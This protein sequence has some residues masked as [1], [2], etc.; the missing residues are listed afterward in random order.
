M[1]DLDLRHDLHRGI[2]AAPV[3]RGY[4]RRH[5]LRA[6]GGRRDTEPIG[7]NLPNLLFEQPQHS[8]KFDPVN[9]M[10][11]KQD[12]AQADTS[13]DHF[14]KHPHVFEPIEAREV[15]ERLAHVTHRQRLP[16]HG[17]DQAADHLIVDELALLLEADFGNDGRGLGVDDTGS[18]DA[19]DK[20]AD[21]A[22]P[23]QNACRTRTSSA[24][25]RS[26]L[27]ERIHEKR[28]VWSY[29]SRMIWSRVDEERLRAYVR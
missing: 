26:S 1:P 10:E 2:A 4:R 8:A 29:S 25:V 3:E 17:L 22:T 18:D 9:R 20:G 16:N 12:I 6:R 7:H 15:R 13:A 11:R 24:Y 21:E 19:N 28:S 14:L 23:H 27:R 5:A